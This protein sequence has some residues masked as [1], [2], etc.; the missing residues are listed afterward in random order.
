MYSIH[1]ITSQNK[2]VAPAAKCRF[3]LLFV[4][5]HCYHCDKCMN[6]DKEFH[7]LIKRIKEKN[8]IR[9]LYFESK[10]LLNAFEKVS[11]LS[12]MLFLI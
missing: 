10:L 5:S 4:D 2:K 11:K 6:K 7:L 3:F 9:K 8:F 12:S 1:D